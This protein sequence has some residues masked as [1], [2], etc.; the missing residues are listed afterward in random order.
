[1]LKT[2]PSGP[3]IHLSQFPIENIYK[4]EHQLL[5]LSSMHDEKKNELSMVILRGVYF[6][7][8]EI[9]PAERSQKNTKV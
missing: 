7:E 1:M 3:R 5:S 8:K 6:R 4:E 2:N 9:K